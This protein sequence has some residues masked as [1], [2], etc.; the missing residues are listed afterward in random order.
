MPTS[1]ETSLVGVTL[2]PQQEKSVK[3]KKPSQKK[4]PMVDF[5]QRVIGKLVT[6]YCNQNSG[7]ETVDG[8]PRFLFADPDGRH[9]IELLASDGSKVYLYLDQVASFVV[10]PEQTQEV[11]HERSRE[12]R[13][14]AFDMR[15]PPGVEV[16]DPSADVEGQPVD[17]VYYSAGRRGP[18]IQGEAPREVRQTQRVDE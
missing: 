13:R 12:P 5:V 15:R 6:F 2:P 1:G 14:T 16:Y 9:L 4:D 7:N 17:E 11:Q 10:Q 18:V 8:V 3:K